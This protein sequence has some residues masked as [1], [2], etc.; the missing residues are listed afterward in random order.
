L[1]LTFAKREIQ[2]V[3]GH[4]TLQMAANYSKRAGQKNLAG[5]AIVK[6]QRKTKTKR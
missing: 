2:A 6:L 5:G 1:P 4:K 3:L